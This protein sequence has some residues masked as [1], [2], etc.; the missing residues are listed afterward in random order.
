MKKILIL[1]VSLQGSNERQEKIKQ[2]HQNLQ[3]TIHDIQ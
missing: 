2:Q 1:C 3:S